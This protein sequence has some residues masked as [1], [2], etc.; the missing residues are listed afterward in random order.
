MKNKNKVFIW[1]DNWWI[2]EDDVWFVGGMS[3]ILF[4]A[5]LNT[6]KCDEAIEIPDLDICKYRLTPS[7]LKCGKDIFCIPGFGQT[8]WVYNLDSKNFTRIDIDKPEHLQIR[9]QLWVKE[10]ALLIV[11]CN[12]NKVMEI[13]ISQKVIKRYYTI[14]EHDTI[15][16]SVL[17]DND[18][19]MVTEDSDNIYRLDL[20]TKT[21]EIYSLQF[22]KK[23]LA[24]ISYDGKKFWLYGYQRELY[25]WDKEDNSFAVINC[26]PKDFGVYDFTEKTDGMVDCEV[27]EYEYSTFLYSVMVGEYIWFI[28]RQTNKILYIGRGSSTVSAFEIYEEQETSESILMRGV[29]GFRFKYLLEYVKHDRYIG[30]FS[31]KHNRILEIDALELKYQW[32][33][34]S[35]SDECLWQCDQIYKGVYCEGQ[36]VLFNQIYRRK[37]WAG[38]NKPHNSTGSGNIGKEIYRELIKE[39]EYDK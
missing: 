13:S 7:C 4:H 26:F 21:T 2:E 32:K 30:L 25:T 11:S 35:F 24:A 16:G 37:L 1:S 9:A 33:D 3:N 31:I 15:Q 19:Y 36:D 14:C 28:P 20:C 38:D 6:G 18:I 23:R 22:C 8:I 34:Y 17:V 39:N 12:W 10:D 29:Y 5:N 27:T